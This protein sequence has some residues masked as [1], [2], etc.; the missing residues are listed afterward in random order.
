MSHHLVTLTDFLLRASAHSGALVGAMR[1]GEVAA[2]FII[3]SFNSARAFISSLPMVGLDTTTLRPFDRINNLVINPLS[4]PSFEDALDLALLLYALGSAFAFVCMQRLCDIAGGVSSEE[5][6]AASCDACMLSIISFAAHEDRDHDIDVCSYKGVFCAPSP[7]N[8]KIRVVAGIDLNHADIVG[9]LPT[10]LGLITDLA[11]LHI[12]SNRFCGVVRS[13]FRKMKL[14]HEL[15][16]SNNQFVGKFPKVVLSLPSLKYLD[17]RFNEFEGYVPSQ[18]FDKPLDAI[19]LN[20]NSIGKM[21]K[22]LNEIILMND[23]LTGCLPPK[24]GMLKKVTVFDISF[25]HLQGAL[26]SSIGNMKS[27]E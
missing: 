19:F 23:N 22:T 2:S 1:L 18:L 15:D 14:L 12:N 9:Y 11:I 6:R 16:L 24:I 25:N 7:K 3:F 21:G 4:L 20:D 5:L 17:L 10:K 8:K 13:S 26:P 27:V